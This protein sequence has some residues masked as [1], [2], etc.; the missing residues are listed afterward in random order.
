[1]KK[2]AAKPPP[3]RSEANKVPSEARLVKYL[4]NEFWWGVLI[5][6]RYLTLFLFFLWG[7]KICF[8]RRILK[9]FFFKKDFIKN[10][11]GLK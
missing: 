8:F 5:V 9:R 3:E 4:Q 1:M 11:E 10:F 7:F 2:T 6:A